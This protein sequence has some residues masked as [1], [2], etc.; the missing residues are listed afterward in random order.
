MSISDYKSDWRWR[1]QDK[2]LNGAV[3]ERAKFIQNDGDHAHCALCWAKFGFNEDDL[4]EG[5]REEGGKHWLCDGCF[6]DFKDIL[7]LKMR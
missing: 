5:W 7:H 4:K 1:G 6:T 3:F 2:Y